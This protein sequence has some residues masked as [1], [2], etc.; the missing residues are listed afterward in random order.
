M[1]ETM[2]EGEFQRAVA[3]AVRGV[4]NV[5]READALLREFAAAME[6]IEP[7]FEIAAKRLVPGVSRKSPDARYLR[8][9][10]ATVLAPPNVDGEGEDEAVEDEDDDGDDDETDELPGRKAIVVPTGG[11]LVVAR[12]AIYDPDHVD[13][14]APNLRITLLGDCRA[15]V[16][17]LADNAQFR[18]KRALF[19]RIV[20]AADGATVGVVQSKGTAIIEGPK[21]ARTALRFAVTTAPIERPLFSLAPDDVPKLAAQVASDWLKLQ[22]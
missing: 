4:L 19:R 10:L 16:P 22:S 12:V 5:Y 18:I 3:A 13:G 2:T 14:F 9:Y 1:S 6:G 7:H 15:V 20:R 17:G 11:S 21:K 8:S